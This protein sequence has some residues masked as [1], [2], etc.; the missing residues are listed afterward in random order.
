[1]ANHYDTRGQKFFEG[2]A[3]YV[4]ECPVDEKSTHR[5]RLRLV[6][7][8]AL[9]ATLSAS[10][11][12][13]E[14]ASLNPEA[15]QLKL[16]D[17]IAGVLQRCSKYWKKKPQ[18]LSS[19]SYLYTFLTALD[20]SD[21]LASG[22]LEGKSVPVDQLVQASNRGI[23]SGRLYGWKLRAFLLKYY[24]SAV[25]KVLDHS[26]ADVEMEGEPL[27]VVGD[28][29]LIPLVVECTEATLQTLSSEK[30]R[31]LYLRDLLEKLEFGADVETQLTSVRCAVAKLS[32][33][34]T[35]LLC[36]LACG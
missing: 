30:D 16:A 13:K 3:S 24:P 8:K 28:S 5:A 26:L 22:Q 6:L 31:L 4:A 7:L 32:G 23:Q 27:D 11:I 2:A 18:E 12:L 14:Q 21:V 19:G 20:S 1:M 29:D 33:W 34:Y 35:L 25:D 36:L 10:S 9:S 17:A 15:V